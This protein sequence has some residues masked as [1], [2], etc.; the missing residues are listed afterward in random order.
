[1]HIGKLLERFVGD[2]L[3]V[4]PPAGNNSA[5][6]ESSIG[7]LWDLSSLQRQW[8][9]RYGLAPSRRKLEADERQVKEQWG[10]LTDDD[11]TVIGGKLEQLEGKFQKRY[12][13]QKDKVRVEVYASRQNM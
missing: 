3:L 12:G 6:A 9:V 13:V 1:M 4:R 10:K 5:A 7:L 8:S 2:D 11:L